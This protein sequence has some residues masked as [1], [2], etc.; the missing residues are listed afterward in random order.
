[1]HWPVHRNWRWLSG[2]VSSSSAQNLFW[3]CLF[4][5]LNFYLGVFD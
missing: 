1:M 5:Y 3:I 2:R 4:F